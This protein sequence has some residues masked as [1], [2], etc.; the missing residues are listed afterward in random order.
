[1]SD[2]L[3]AAIRRMIALNQRDDKR[4]RSNEAFK[5][6]CAWAVFFVILGLIFGCATKEPAR[7]AKA[8]PAIP[9]DAKLICWKGAWT[10][11]SESARQG[12][13]YSH[14][15]CGRDAI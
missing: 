3:D 1:M 4:E 7:V 6:A 13:T 2:D 10:V 5:R 8:V 11:Y 14:A 9:K 15:P 12:A